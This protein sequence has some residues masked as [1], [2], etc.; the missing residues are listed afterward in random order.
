MSLQQYQYCCCCTIPG[1]V[2]TVKTEGL[3]YWFTFCILSSTNTATA[4]FWNEG[5][6]AA[7]AYDLLFSTPT[8]HSLYLHLVDFS[9]ICIN[10]VLTYV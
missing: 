10:L 6:L 3:N 1:G 5:T 9:G 8:S 2:R 4:V 7:C